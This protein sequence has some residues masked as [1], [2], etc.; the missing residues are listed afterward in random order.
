MYMGRIVSLTLAVAASIGFPAAPADAGEMPVRVGGLGVFSVPVTS[1][2]ESRFK[3][4]IKQEYDYSCGAASVATLL[5]FHYEKPTPEKDVFL[6]MYEAGDKERIERSGFSLLDM[7]G[8]LEKIGLRA[9]G[10]KISLEQYAGAGVPA[11]T[12]IET[13]GYRHFVVI[14]GIDDREVLV[15][16]PAQGMKVYT[17]SEFKSLW[18]GVIF[19]V[20]D[21]IDLARKKFNLKDDWKL[22]EK[23]PFGTALS[24]ES[25]GMF[26]LLLPAGN[27]F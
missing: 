11:I 16:D 7:Q 8:Y 27:E 13:G 12:I 20:R 18:K 17:R 15:G 9:D 14:K 10:F 24:R 25:L 21:D 19:A 5:S 2:K 23:A 3:T 22:K 1:V 26:T 4:V 6:A